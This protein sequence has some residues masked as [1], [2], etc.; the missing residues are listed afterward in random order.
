MQQLL[1]MGMEEGLRSAM[2]QLD[3]VLAGTAPQAAERA[4]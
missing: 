2:G 4:G 1:E 3:G